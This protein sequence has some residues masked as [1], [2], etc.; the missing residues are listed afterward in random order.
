VDR[1]VQGP[2]AAK[3]LSNVATGVASQSTWLIMSQVDWLYKALRQ[4]YFGL[5]ICHFG[6]SL[7]PSQARET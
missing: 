2:V 6:H 5:P 4:R 3:R 7:T 1:L